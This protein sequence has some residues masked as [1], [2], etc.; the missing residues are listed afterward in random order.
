MAGN[1]RNFA[2]FDY[3][4][5]SAR[6]WNVRG[7][8]GG[9]GAAID[10]HTTDLALPKWGA[11]TP[12]RHPRYCV[13]EDGTTHRTIKTIIYTPSAYAAISPGDTL[14]ALFAGVAAAVTMTLAA[15]VPEKQP[16][17]KAA[18]NLADVA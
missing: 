12:G 13:W 4:D 1:Q 7:E 3:L 15:K 6:H 11:Q 18:R 16:L 17:A 2:N 14:D 8:S 9:P 5:D 10:G